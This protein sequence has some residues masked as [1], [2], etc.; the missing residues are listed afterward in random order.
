MELYE[1]GLLPIQAYG[2]NIY[3]TIEMTKFYFAAIKVYVSSRDKAEGDSCCRLEGNT[4]PYSRAALASFSPSY[5]S[6]ILNLCLYNRTRQNQTCQNWKTVIED[7]LTIK[8][9][10]V[11]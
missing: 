2:G 11:R 5:L 6:N 8:F 9:L 10:K 3:L 7:L 4:K 1:P